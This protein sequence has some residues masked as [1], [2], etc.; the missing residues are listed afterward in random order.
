VK[1]QLEVKMMK[2]WQKRILRFV[3]HLIGLRGG[4]LIYVAFVIDVDEE[5]TINDLIKNK[6]EDEMNR[7][8]DKETGE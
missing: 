8:A 2:Q 3:S 1:R 6:E 7:Q 4:H 5:P